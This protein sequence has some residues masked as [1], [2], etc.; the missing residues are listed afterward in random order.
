MYV[1]FFGPYCYQKTV[2]LKRIP[3]VYTNNRFVNTVISDFE[4]YYR[5]VS[6]YFGMY[7]FKS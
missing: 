5:H 1:D 7:I 2:F 4:K 6:F 3:I